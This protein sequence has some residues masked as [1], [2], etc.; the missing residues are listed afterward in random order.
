MD[1]KSDKFK[2]VMMRAASQFI[3]TESNHQSLITVTDVAVSKDFQKATIFVT[4]FP[5]HKQEAV[6]DFLQ[7]QKREF[8]QF[9]MTHT[10]IGKIPMF[11]F[12]I[13]LGEKIRQKID[14]AI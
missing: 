2:E 3:Q 6:I 5:D 13:D 7:R 11:D 14:E 12:A 9:I 8:K 4:V 10:K 1:H